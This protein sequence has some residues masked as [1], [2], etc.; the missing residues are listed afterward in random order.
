MA[1]KALK[2]RIR[3]ALERGLFG[4]PGDVVDVSDGEVKETIHVVV[5]S[6]KF[7]GR[8][9]TEKIDLI[10][11]ELER[12]LT[13]DERGHVTLSIGVSPAEVNGATVREL[14]LR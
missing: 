3:D 6:P 13:P 8:G 7:T 9:T 12:S 14:K 2:R 10:C 1:D 5:I 11:S 4:G